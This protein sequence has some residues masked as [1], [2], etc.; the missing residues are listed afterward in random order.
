MAASS[1]WRSGE[2]REGE[3]VDVQCPGCG[4]EFDETAFELLC[5]HCVCKTCASEADSKTGN[6]FRYLI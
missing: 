4:S 5:G 3:K 6:F 1:S 2:N